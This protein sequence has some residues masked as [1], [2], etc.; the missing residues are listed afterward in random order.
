MIQKRAKKGFFAVEDDNFCFEGY[1][2]KK[3]H[4]Q[5]ICN[6]LLYKKCSRTNA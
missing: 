5:R 1:S 6:T 3:F 2:L 4:F